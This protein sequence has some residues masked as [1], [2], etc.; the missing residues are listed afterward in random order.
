MNILTFLPL[1]FLIGLMV[2]MT[3]SA[4]KKQQQAADMRDQMQ[5][6]TGIRTIGGVYATVK[7]VHQDTVLLEIAPGVHT[8]FAKNAVAAVLDDDEYHRIVHGA[9]PVTGASAVPDDASSLTGPGEGPVVGLD[10]TGADVP[11]RPEGE[12]GP[13][14]GAKE[15]KR[16]DGDAGG[17]ADAK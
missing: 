15:N 4:K 5:P 8:V 1:I 10:K 12:A 16:G 2:L 13:A 7:E 9:E 3:R 6:G 14:G 11:E 17:D